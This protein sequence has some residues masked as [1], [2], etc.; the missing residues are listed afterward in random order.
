MK[1]YIDQ[2]EGKKAS[3]QREERR[4]AAWEGR[5]GGRERAGEMEKGAT[6]ASI[7]GSLGYRPWCQIL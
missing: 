1:G 4:A 5:E 3:E 6:G 2:R 7:G